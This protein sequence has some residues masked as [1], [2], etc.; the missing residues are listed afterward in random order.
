MGLRGIFKLDLNNAIESVKQKSGGDLFCRGGELNA[1]VESLEKVGMFKKEKRSQYG[2]NLVRQRR[3]KDH[4]V[5]SGAY[6]TRLWRS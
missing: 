3:G 1:K 6:Y 5:E 4:V 2:W